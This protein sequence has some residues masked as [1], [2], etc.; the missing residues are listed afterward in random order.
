MHEA[1]PMEP[2]NQHQGARWIEEIAEVLGAELGGVDQ[3]SERGRD[4]GRYTIV[5]AGAVGQAQQRLQRRLFA[6]QQQLRRD[7]DRLAR[8]IIRVGR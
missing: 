8:R 2:A 1:L 5:L 6:R 4:P 3:H 7:G